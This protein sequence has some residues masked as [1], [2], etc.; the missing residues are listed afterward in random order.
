MIGELTFNSEEQKRPTSQEADSLAVS[1]SAG[2]GGS[3]SQ[4]AASGRSESAN[5]QNGKRVHH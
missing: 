2:L 4:E 5:S 3:P 1:S